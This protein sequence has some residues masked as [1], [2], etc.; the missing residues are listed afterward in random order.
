[1]LSFALYAPT[2]GAALGRNDTHFSAQRRF[3]AAQHLKQPRP[4]RHHSHIFATKKGAPSGTPLKFSP[5]QKDQLLVAL[6]M[7][8]ETPG[9]MVEEI[10]IF[11]M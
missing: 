3:T 7:F 10:A 8:S 1:M 5:D 11:F 4:R 6:S 2:S 9:P